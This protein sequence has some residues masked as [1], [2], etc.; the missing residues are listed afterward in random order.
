MKNK[1][2]NFYAISDPGTCDVLIDKDTGMILVFTTQEK[3]IKFTETINKPF[4]ISPVYL[5]TG[6]DTQGD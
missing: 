6:D 3:A 4:A 2:F 1:P 5:I